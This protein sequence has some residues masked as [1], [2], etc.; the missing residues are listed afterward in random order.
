MIATYE[1]IASQLNKE[2]FMCPSDYPYLYMNNEKTS[3][4]LGSKRHWRSINKTLCTFLAPT[5]FIDKYW[6]NFKKNCQD[7]HDPFEKYLNELYE[8]ELCISP[9]KSLSVHFANINSSYGLSPYINYKALWE[10]N[11]YDQKY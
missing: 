11:N 6:D 9:V 1:R 7:R 10:E 8:K 2:I 4:L 3:L 5:S